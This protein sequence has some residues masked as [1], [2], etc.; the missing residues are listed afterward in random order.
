LV[1]IVLFGVVIDKTIKSP[2][3]PF[4]LKLWVLLIFSIFLILLP[5]IITNTKASFYEVPVTRTVQCFWWLALNLFINETI[6]YFV[7]NG[8]LA[9]KGITG[10]KLLRDL[11]SSLL[12]II[13]LACIFNFVF[14]KAV[15]GIF[16]AS[17]VMAIILGYSAQATLGEAFAGVGLNITKQF[18][19]GDTINVNGNTGTV[20]DINWRFVIL[21]TKDG[22]HLSI[23]NSQISKSNIINYSRPDP[24]HGVS[25]KVPIKQIFSPEAAKSMLLSAADQCFDISTQR[26]PKVELVE[27]G[28]NGSSFN[29]YNLSYYTT[30]SS[31]QINDRI[32]SILWYKSTKMERQ[33]TN[34][35]QAVSRDEVRLFLK[36]LDLFAPLMDKE[37]DA[38]T[39]QTK[40]CFYGPPE[41][42][43][44]QGQ[45]NQS[46]FLIYKGG[47]DVCINTPSGEVTQVAS[48]PEGNYFGE[49]S[50][51]TGEEAG[52]SIIVNTESII[53]EITSAC[54]A[55]LFRQRPEL[56]EKISEVIVRRK[57]CN[58]HIRASLDEQD[59]TERVSM[60]S[61]LA[62]R[63]KH[64]FKATP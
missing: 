49:M 14:D 5:D 59:K 23:P 55:Q 53:I 12:L 18:D 40:R 37:I 16:T 3:K 60:I 22:N 7:W 1:F 34:S 54:M 28:G 19:K 45:N 13:T 25:I 46:L 35:S 63:I 38:L 50:L 20:E 51:L 57:L 2:I 17:G 52:A 39:E 61:V 30:K 9:H 44:L 6:R 11:L 58:E 62:N 42:I 47:V 33:L 64:F 31:G 8:L 24:L 26:P 21:L 48:L 56:V 29:Q 27:L 43:L 4:V 10:S 41:R 15:A 32:L 36:E